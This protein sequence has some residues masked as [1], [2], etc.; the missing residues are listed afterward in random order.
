MYWLP[1]WTVTMHEYAIGHVTLVA[2]ILGMRTMYD[3]A[4]R[5]NKLKSCVNCERLNT[6]SLFH[7]VL[8]EIRLAI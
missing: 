4:L 2:A 6:E 7:N 1:H 3:A 5:R 8:V